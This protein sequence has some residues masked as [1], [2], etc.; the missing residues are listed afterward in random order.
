MLEAEQALPF[1][2]VRWS[3]SESFT[4]A[5]KVW[6]QK[7]QQSL[8]NVR[9]VSFV[10]LIGLVYKGIRILSRSET[11]ACRIRNDGATGAAC[12]SSCCRKWLCQTRQG[13][14]LLL[15][16]WLPGD[17]VFSV[18]NAQ[19]EIQNAFTLRCFPPPVLDPS[20]RLWNTWKLNLS[21]LSESPWS[22]D[23]SEYLT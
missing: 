12:P 4:P 3:L 10:D 19:E 17:D 9:N 15:P 11:H 2:A 8:D 5:M 18:T 1:L 21:H 6:E 23:G 22:R 13:V 20:R 14:K 7:S 16:Q